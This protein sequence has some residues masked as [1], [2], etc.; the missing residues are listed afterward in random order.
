MGVAMSKDDTLKL[1]VQLATA[2]IQ[3]NALA[4]SDDPA[5]KLVLPGDLMDLVEMYVLK[6]NQKFNA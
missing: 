3:A 4:K 5:A 1:A 2:Q 6:L